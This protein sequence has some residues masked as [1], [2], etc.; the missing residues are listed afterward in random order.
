MTFPV[1]RLISFAALAC[2][3]G[4]LPLFAQGQI[5][6]REYRSTINLLLTSAAVAT[7]ARLQRDDAALS[8]YENDPE[9]LG[10]VYQA[11]GAVEWPRHQ[12]RPRRMI[13]PFPERGTN[14]LAPDEAHAIF[15][16]AEHQLFRDQ[17]DK[18]PDD[19][20]QHTCNYC[21]TIGPVLGQRRTR[22][23]YEKLINTHVGLFPGAENQFRP[24]RTN[25]SMEE[26]P[27]ALT[28]SGSGYPGM[29]GGSPTPMA[30]HTRQKVFRLMSRSTIWQRISR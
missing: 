27:I 3:L 16:E 29:A 18:I 20:L 17:S 15:W 2:G 21:H 23:D 26:A 14:G 9:S 30:A 8:Y 22:A 7:R 1:S 12:A 5:R 13:S 6:S 28:V 19:A 4:C 11:H 25:R 24:R 10:R